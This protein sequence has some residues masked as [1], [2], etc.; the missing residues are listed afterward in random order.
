MV[1]GI[2]PDILL[3]LNSLQQ[4]YPNYQ[5]KFRRKK[6]K[7]SFYLGDQRHYNQQ[8]WIITRLSQTSYS[9]VLPMR[10]SHQIDHLFSYIY[11]THDRLAFMNQHHSYKKLVTKLTALSKKSNWKMMRVLNLQ[12][13]YP[14]TS[15]ESIHQLQKL[16]VKTCRTKYG[17]NNK[18][19]IFQVL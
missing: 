15:Y 13:H 19:I 8:S 10:S 5:I 3:F 17:N 11:V 12:M 16:L 4:S 7:I 14:Q 2:E 6:D 1:E 18:N 9:L